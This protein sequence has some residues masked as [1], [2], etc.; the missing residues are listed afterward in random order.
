MIPSVP[1]TTTETRRRMYDC[2]LEGENTI[3]VH[4]ITP[5]YEFLGRTIKK[6]SELTRIPSPLKKDGIE[7]PGRISPYISD[8]TGSVKKKWK[9]T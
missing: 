3:S 4:R 6:P 9:N 8:T 1:R 7:G 2:S 5:R